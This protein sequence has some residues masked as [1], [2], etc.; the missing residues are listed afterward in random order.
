MISQG[1]I[2][3]IAIAYL[4]TLFLI[5]NLSERKWFNFSSSWIYALSMAVYCTAWT[6]FG[7]IGN[8]A[9]QGLSFLPVYLGPTLFMPL[10]APVLIKLIRIS[11]RQRITSIAD[12]I[13]SRYGKNVSLGI[14]V[15][16]FCVIGIVPYISIQLK[17]I[18]SGIEI[19][20][21]YENIHGWWKDSTL[22]IAAGLA[23]FTIV[24]GIRHIDATEQHKGVMSAIAFES[25]VKLI[26][27]IVCGLVICYSS[28]HNTGEI[29]KRAEA[30]NLLKAFTSFEHFNSWNWILTALVSALSII[31]LPRQFQ[32]A[33][34]ENTDVKHVRKSMW[35]FPFYLLLINLLVI[36]IALAGKL[37]I[38][39]AS[40][41]NYFLLLIQQLKNPGLSSLVFI[42]GFSAA[43]GMVIVEVIALTTMISNH[44]LA[45]MFLTRSTKY[46]HDA[47]KFILNARRIAAIFLLF[48][49][50]LFEKQVAER[51]SLISIGLISF[52]AMAQLAPSVLFGLF[53]KESNRKAAVVSILSGFLLWFYTLV[54]PSFKGSV[55]VDRLLLQGPFS[56]SWLK[57]TELFGLNT[58]DPISHGI[59]WSLGINTL[60]FIA[61]AL[62][63]KVENSVRIQQE[64]FLHPSKTKYPKAIWNGLTLYIDLKR[65]LARFIGEK[66]VDLLLQGYANRHD[67]IIQEEGPADRRM[68]LFAE[69]LLGGV[70]GSAS[71]RLM[72]SSVTSEEK[73]SLNEVMDIVKESQ[74][75]IE[76]NKEL[77]KKSIELEKA[78][79]ALNVANEKLL[80]ADEMKNEFLYTVTHELRTPLTSIRALSEILH[81]N[82]DLDENQRQQ[83]LSIITREIE[84]L[85][86]LI[87]QVLNLEKYESGRQRIQPIS[88]D[89]ND[90]LQEVMDSLRPLAQEKNKYFVCNAPN[91]Q[92]LIHADRSLLVQVVYNLVSN[93]IKFANQKIEIIIRKQ[94]D[95][96]E[97]QISDDGPGIDEHQKDL[98]FDKF[99]QYKQHHLLKP[100]GSG[101]GLA[102]CRR[103]I[104]LHH[105]K[106][107]ARNN[108]EQGASFIFALPSI[109]QE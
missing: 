19:L 9:E 22:Y 70:V 49:A 73:I 97:V 8:A 90:L 28:F 57:P 44:V 43:T 107:T 38:A 25:V 106:I 12:F 36:P 13:S 42:G 18:T 24:Y 85:S 95:E 14:V 83:Y 76:L 93:A 91:E 1:V 15:T 94:G 87:T 31:F 64:L 55:W 32:V 7:S 26:A 37:Q 81:D 47:G 74:Q 77:R 65:M 23:L 46:T 82:P 61:L 88:F 54:L 80:Y 4:S 89:M 100:E 33:V 78:S 71:S 45:P 40:S 75:I 105:G 102:I 58:L 27:F 35:V 20:T 39:H 104:E 62:Q 101:L 41:D 6:F 59:F 21:G 53:W 79:S 92:L 29:F 10:L 99:Y 86:H 2:I 50:Y 72:I 67:I 84:K 69:R 52:T 60:L 11:K 98:L 5:A 109:F 56:L 66:R 63:G 108:R 51:Y 34:V 30:N 68:V 96:F 103:I 3:A 16:I 48:F 17:A